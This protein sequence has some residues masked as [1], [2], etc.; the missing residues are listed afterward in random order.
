MYI[1]TKKWTK[2]TSIQIVHWIREWNKVK[3]KVLKHIW[4]KNNTDSF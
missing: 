3:Q 1:R 2:T 4:T